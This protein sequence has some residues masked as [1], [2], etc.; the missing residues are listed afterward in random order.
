MKKPILNP[1]LTQW[2]RKIVIALLSMCMFQQ[3]NY[4]QNMIMHY[5]DPGM[6][7]IDYIQGMPWGDGY[8]LGGTINPPNV[9]GFNNNIMPWGNLGRIRFQATD[10]DLNTQMFITYVENDEFILMSASSCGTLNLHFTATDTKQTTDGGAIICGRVIRNG[11][12]TNCGGQQID[13]PYILKVRNDGSVDWYK[14]YDGKANFTSIVEDVATKRYIVC[15]SFGLE[16][17]ILGIDNQGNYNWATNTPPPSGA[18]FSAEFSEVAPFIANGQTYYAVVGNEFY[19]QSV[20]NMLLTVVDIN[21]NHFQD[22]VIRQ[23]IDQDF[24]GAWGVHDANDMTNVVIT[25][26]ASFSNLGGSPYMPMIMKIDPFTLALSFAKGYSEYID[27]NYFVVG[28][29][30]SISQGN[31]PL[32]NISVTGHSII[33]DWQYSAAFWIPAGMYLEVNTNGNLMRYTRIQPN[34]A[35]SGLGI[36]N[37]TNTNYPAFVGVDDIA[38][39]SFAIRNNYGYDCGNDIPAGEFD[40]NL[41]N[42][43]INYYHINL[44]SKQHLLLEFAVPINEGMVCGMLTPAKATGVKTILNTK[45]A[46]TI[47]PNPANNVLQINATNIALKNIVV[48]DI[49]GRMM[50]NQSATGSTAK[51]DI[52]QFKAGTYILQTLTQDGNTYNQKFVKE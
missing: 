14:R 16:A 52:S 6:K 29:G 51:L 37:N 19:Q 47:L 31:G 26:Q 20:K 15:G 28:N 35:Y 10:I 30:R 27:K 8:Y 24:M 22:V 49:T 5:P 38:A 9:G 40:I 33:T 12:M 21:I 2:S 13:E 34:F 11:E 32:D 4:A 1:Q 36:V 7:T 45:E 44:Q 50:M 39:N 18:Q 43:P 42:I 41:Y 48:Y 25:G 46:I 23:N 3:L 17:L